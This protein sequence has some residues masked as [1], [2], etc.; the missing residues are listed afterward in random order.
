MTSKL[1][2]GRVDAAVRLRA[3]L[4]RRAPAPPR[5]NALQFRQRR[6]AISLARRPRPRARARLTPHGSPSTQPAMIF[7]RSGSSHPTSKLTPGITRPET[8]KQAFKL[9]NDIRPE[10]GRVHAHVRPPSGCGMNAQRSLSHAATSGGANAGIT[11][12]AH[13]LETIPCRWRPILLSR[14]ARLFSLVAR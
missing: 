2:R 8:T 5:Q 6:P 12:R 11:R 13:N 7:Q 3:T 4:A 9:A 10:S 14:L 1:I